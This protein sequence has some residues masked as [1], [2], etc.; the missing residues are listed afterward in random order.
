MLF[1][2]S[3]EIIRP[4]QIKNI[5]EDVEYY[6][7]NCQEAD[8]CENELIYEDIDGLEEMLL[9]VSNVS[10]N[11]PYFTIQKTILYF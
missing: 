1:E 7:D 5:K 3:I 8:F 9:D 11:K 10:I 6:I 2:A 4:L